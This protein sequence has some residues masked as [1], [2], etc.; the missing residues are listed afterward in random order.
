LEVD[1]AP[2]GA[3]RKERKDDQHLIRAGWDAGPGLMQRPGEAGGRPGAGSRAAGRSVPDDVT[4]GWHCQT[5]A[6]VLARPKGRA[7]AIWW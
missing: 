4:A 1:A 3:M 6:R 2:R 7:E 5:P